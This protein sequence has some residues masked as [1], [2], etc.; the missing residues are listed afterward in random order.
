M[1]LETQIKIHLQ[2]LKN[3]DPYVTSKNRYQLRNMSP[4][5]V[6]KDTRFLNPEIEDARATETPSP[7]KSNS[8]KTLLRSKPATPTNFYYDG[9]NRLRNKQWVDNLY[10]NGKQKLMSRS[11]SVY[12]SL[13]E[14]EE[15][16]E[17]TFHPRIKHNL[18]L[19]KDYHNSAKSLVLELNKQPTK[20]KAKE[21]KRIKEEEERKK[22]TFTPQLISE[23]SRQ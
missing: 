19:K 13:K 2:T 1:V 10:E 20:E 5:S 17:C 23:G 11:R 6:D 8:P 12:M 15:L 4:Y 18:S 9:Y 14:A 7:R 3:R 21:F 16:K 22:C